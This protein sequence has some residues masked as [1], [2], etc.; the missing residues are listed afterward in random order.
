MRA[1]SAPMKCGVTRI[2][3]AVINTCTARWWPFIREVRRHPHPHRRDQY[4]YGEVVAV[5]PQGPRTIAVRVAKEPHPVAVCAR[6]ADH[7]AAVPLHL[8]RSARQLRP[9]CAV[10]RDQQRVDGLT[11]LAAETLGG[12][13]GA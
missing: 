6:G 9:R 11:L 5:H 2:P 4:V 13:P 1:G 3:T 12:Q 7:G 8:D 10:R